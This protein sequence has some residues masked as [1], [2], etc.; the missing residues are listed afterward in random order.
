MK[1][2]HLD[3]STNIC[4]DSPGQQYKNLIYFNETSYQFKTNFNQRQPLLD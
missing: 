2:M 3:Y 4:L 1:R